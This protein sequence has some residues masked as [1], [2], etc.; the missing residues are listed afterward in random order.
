MHIYISN[1]AEGC[2]TYLILW[3]LCYCYR[4]L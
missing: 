3:Y 2:R 4:K 1:V